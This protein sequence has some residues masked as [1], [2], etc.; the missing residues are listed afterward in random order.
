MAK[1]NRVTR[2]ITVEFRPV[3]KPRDGVEVVVTPDS[4]VVRY[5][6][7][8]QWN[9]QGA[10]ARATVTVGNFAAFGPCPTA[11]FTSGKVRFK[12]PNAMKDEKVVE[13]NGVLTYKLS[14]EDPGLYKYTVSVDG[15][16]VLDPDVEIKG[17]R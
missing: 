3:D 9:V 14:D 1:Y 10:P 7:I 15:T 5:G 13:R 17:P 16:V 11:R 4:A 12:K 2:V 6:D 8:I